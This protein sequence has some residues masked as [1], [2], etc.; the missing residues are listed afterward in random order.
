MST[1]NGTGVPLTTVTTGRA[2][3]V[4]RDRRAVLA[5][6][7]WL[8]QQHRGGASHVEIGAVLAVLDR[9]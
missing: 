3:S 9:V 1:F 8:A 5:L 6:R 2:P 7:T 4:N